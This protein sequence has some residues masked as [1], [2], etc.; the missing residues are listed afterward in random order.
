MKT[1]FYR[2]L[3]ALILLFA[4]AL[5]LASA[6]VVTTNYT[7]LGNN[8]WT[9]ELALTNDSDAAGINE[10]TIYF[11]PSMFSALSVQSSPAGWDSFV[12]QPDAALGAPGFFDSF[13]AQALAF[14]SAQT[15]FSVGFTFLGQGA[16]GQLAFDIVGPDFVATS[17]GLTVAL[18]Q[19]SAAVPEPSPML[20]LTAGMLFGLGRRA[21]QGGAA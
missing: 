7:N 17:S 2:R 15:G 13:N 11:S 18:K 9:V 10:M 8:L 4:G 1:F 16:P 12:A 3:V 19:P 14:G 5:P 6:A 21:R 20:L